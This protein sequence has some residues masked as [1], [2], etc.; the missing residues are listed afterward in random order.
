MDL[1][2]S[3]PDRKIASSLVKRWG[4]SAMC[5][6]VGALSRIDVKR[7]ERLERWTSQLGGF[8][9]FDAR[10]TVDNE[11]GRR[12]GLPPSVKTF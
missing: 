6:F 5:A 11:K 4:M 1:F 10:H 7:T 9:S 3:H 8:R 2:Y 12:R